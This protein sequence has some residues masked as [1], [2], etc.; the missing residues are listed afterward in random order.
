MSSIFP[1]Q[2][3]EKLK[4]RKM[5]IQRPKHGKNTLPPSYLPGLGTEDALKEQLKGRTFQIRISY[6]EIVLIL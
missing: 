5:K 4:Q 2:V 1:E 6:A 3:T